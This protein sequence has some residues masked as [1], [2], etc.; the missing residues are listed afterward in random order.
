MERNF[1]FKISL[2]GITPPI[3][4]TFVVKE[5]ISFFEFHHV[6]QIVMGWFNEHLYEFSNQS[7]T[8]A[9]PELVDIDEVIDVNDFLLNEY[10]EI[11]GDRIKYEYDFGDTWIHDIVLE[12]ITDGGE[13][14]D[15]PKCLTGKRNCPPENCGGKYGYMN[16]VEIMSDENHPDFEEMVDLFGERFDPEYF[17]LDEINAFLDDFMND[18]PDSIIDVYLN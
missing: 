11:Q 4:R 7:I 16:I 18:F 15:V 1:Q 14:D 8:I 13:N 9:D 2:K 17:D 5:N 10:F 12:K 3:F 6:I